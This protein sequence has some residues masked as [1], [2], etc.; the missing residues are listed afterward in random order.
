MSSS[1]APVGICA[2]VTAALFHSTCKENKT[3]D[4]VVIADDTPF[5]ATERTASGTREIRASESFFYSIWRKPHEKVLANLPERGVVPEDKVPYSGYWY[6]E[7]RSN[8]SNQEY[9]ANFKGGT[10]IGDPSP[11]QKYDQAY[12]AGQNKAVEWEIRNHTRAPDDKDASWAGH[13][14]G[15]SASAQR[16]RE[17]QQDVAVGSVT[18]TAR[19]IKAL[20]AEIHMSAKFYI[21]GGNRCDDQQK[22]N[23]PI[24]RG[25]R[26]DPEIMEECEDV[27]PGVFHLAV[28]NWVG[29][30]NHAI[31]FD[32]SY[33]DQVWNYPLY[34]YTIEEKVDSLTAAQVRS[35]Y[36]SEAGANYVYNP[37]AQSFA[38]IRMR[39]YYADATGPNTGEVLNSHRRKSALY[40]Y[41]LELDGDGAVIGGEWINTQC[42]RSVENHP[43]FV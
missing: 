42:T 31:I 26:V 14:N 35:Q 11:L 24:H 15:F 9:N 33:K 32:R 29:R 21:L 2:L 40:E 6:P 5:V 41:I 4:R 39:V 37:L 22:L 34:E 3:G 7:K 19:D 20:L 23:K 16:H 27:N 36:I 1:W 17:P 8:Y 30:Q 12:N 10:H 28:T 38:Y 13:C 18:F 43:D 25:Q